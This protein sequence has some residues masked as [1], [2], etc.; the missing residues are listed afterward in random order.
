M[1]KMDDLEVPDQTVVV[2]VSTV[3]MMV[4]EYD[5]DPKYNQEKA[6]YNNVCDLAKSHE[7]LRD[8][9]IKILN[10]EY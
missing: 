1:G 5:H 8:M 2:G 10:A 4:E 3:R 6:L 9:L 7:I